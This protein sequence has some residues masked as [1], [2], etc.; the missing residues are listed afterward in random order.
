TKNQNDIK[1]E[2]GNVD[3]I[4]SDPF[5]PNDDV[6]SKQAAQTK[7][8]ADDVGKLWQQLYDRQRQHVLEW[9]QELSKEFRDYVDKL[10]FGAE[11]RSD[12]RNHYLNYIDNHFPALPKIIDAR[13]ID[14][15]TVGSGPGGGE[16]GR[17]HVGEISTSGEATDDNDYI[18]EWEPAD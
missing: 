2:F 13:A 10:Q 14:A 8:Q 16:F 3:K 6:N 9:P 12:Y 15:T 5:H 17:S 4:R 11:I 1:A 7:K 18:C